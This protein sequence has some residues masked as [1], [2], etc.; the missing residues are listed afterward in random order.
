MLRFTSGAM[1]NSEYMSAKLARS[2]DLF[3]SHPAFDAVCLAAAALGIWLLAA[4]HDRRPGIWP[5]LI[6]LAIVLAS[7]A[8]ETALWFHP[9]DIVVL[10]ALVG[11]FTMRCRLGTE[12]HPVIRVIYAA[13]LVGGLITSATSSNGFYNFPIGGLAAAALAPA[14]LVPRGAPWNAVAAQCG[15]LLLTVVLFCASAFAS[16][17]GETSNPLTARAVR[18]NDGPFAG[19]LTTTDQAAFIAAATAALREHVG[20]GG[21][22]VVMGRPSGIYLLTDASPMTLSNWDFWQF[23][24]SLPPWVN[25]LFEAFYRV[26][27]HRPDVVAVFA[28]P[29]TYPLAPWARDLLADYVVAERVSIGSWSLSVYVR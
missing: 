20:R 2:L 26:P 16:V 1:Q 3:V 25:A 22:I 13:S 19:L 9:H 11:L 15:M 12:G 29:R 18:V 8:T 5:S 7:Y 17:Y 4:G 6:V 28:D 27:A 10:L 14:M 23:Y 21:T 24:G